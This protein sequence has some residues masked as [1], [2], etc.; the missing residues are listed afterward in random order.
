M[1]EEPQLIDLIAMIA[2]PAVIQAFRGEDCES[3]SDTSYEFAYLMMKA[4]EK[5]LNN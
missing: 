4:R 2:L 1:N 5:Y 3:A